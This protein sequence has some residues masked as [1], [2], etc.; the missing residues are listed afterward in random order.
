ME[1][2]KEVL[3]EGHP[4]TLTSM[5]N[6]AMTYSNQGRWEEAEK[7]VVEVMEKRKEVL[8]EGHPSTLTSMHNLAFTLWGIGRRQSAL[9]LISSCADMSQARLGVDHPDTVAAFSRRA[10]WEEEDIRDDIADDV[11]TTTSNDTEEEDDED[12]EDVED[13]D[14][15]DEEHDAAAGQR[16]RVATPVSVEGLNSS[17]LDSTQNREMWNRPQFLWML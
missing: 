12:D 13:V 10:L 7:L 17:L 4:S 2:R 8:G 5:N 3:G 15:H 6:L 14:E 16:D 11:R 1:K 9:D